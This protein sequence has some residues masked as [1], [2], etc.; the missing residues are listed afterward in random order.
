MALL[1][2]TCAPMLVVCTRTSA[3]KF[4][5]QTPN[6][7]RVGRVYADGDHLRFSHGFTKEQY[8]DGLIAEGS[9]SD[10]SLH[11]SNFGQ[12][13]IKT[14]QGRDDTLQMKA[15]GFLEGYLTAER[16][17]DHWY[18]YQFWF[19]G[20]GNGTRALQRWLVQQDTWIRQQ[21]ELHTGQTS[22]EQDEAASTQGF[23]YA[24][25]LVLQQMDGILQGYN[26][27]VAELGPGS[28]MVY[29][30]KEALLLMNAYGDMNDLLPIFVTDND[31]EVTR[32]L[33]KL[34]PE[35]A[36]HR[37]ATG[38]HCSALVKVTG[39]LSDIM[40]GHTTWGTYYTMVRVYKHF[41]F[42]GLASHH[43][44]GTKVSMSSYPG[45]VTSMDD[46]YI[47]NPT[48]LVVMETTNDVYDT[49][50]YADVHWESALS[51]HRVFAANLVAD[52]GAAW[53]NLVQ[54]YNSGTYNN[55][56]MVVDLKRFTPGTE[57]K[58]GLLTV[59]ELLPGF[60]MSADVTHELERGF[61]P[62]YNVPYFREIYDKAGYPA[63]AAALTARG[64]EYATV[65]GG[66]SY[67]L[68]PR[69][70]IFRRDA[71]SVKDVKDLT[72]LLRSNKW[73]NDTY[74]G[75]DVW[76][77]LCAR[78]DLSPTRPTAYGCHDAKGTSYSLALQS[79]ALAVSGPSADSGLPP[80]SWSSAE[81]F[82]KGPH[83]GMPDT[84]N[85]KFE[86]QKP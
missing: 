33:S 83:R 55:Q 30:H 80:F 69:A 36:W 23:W 68:A 7:P 56:Y 66:L 21:V 61:W 32:D 84:F 17:F 25:S 28:G 53:V 58:A 73:H 42:Q 39:D 2:N 11:K 37:L 79:A 76:G 22:L 54:M 38:G 12:L 31:E 77:T 45:A 86:L 51:Y 49:S 20:K 65:V 27:R 72:K 75:N 71:G 48:K 59:I 15:A 74:S 4:T 24:V 52:N 81:A 67:Q 40:I 16:L 19:Q 18:N 43:A 60:S 70:K 13:R 9:F 50:L 3:D 64:P 41:D 14:L 78:G 29:M 82:A 57:L 8:H 47:I 62:S 63:M 1:L 34:S 26:A 5:M 44:R 10:G 85:G 6:R 35:A 46:F